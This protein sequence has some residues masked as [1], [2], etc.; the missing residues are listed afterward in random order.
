MQSSSHA[1]RE[2]AGIAD[3]EKIYLAARERSISHRWNDFFE[4][5]LRLATKL[6][7]IASI[8]KHDRLKRDWTWLEDL[9][10]DLSPRY[11]THESD[12]DRRVH[13][14]DRLRAPLYDDTVE[15]RG[16]SVTADT[17]VTAT[18]T[19]IYVSRGVRSRYHWGLSCAILRAAILPSNVGN[20]VYRYPFSRSYPFLLHACTSSNRAT[21]GWGVQAQYM[22]SSYLFANWHS[23]TFLFQFVSKVDIQFFISSS[24]LTLELTDYATD[25]IVN[26]M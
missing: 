20:T 16:T 22:Y 1:W 21:A 18:V 15:P 9:K 26:S 8:V 10:Y 2:R 13:T 4:R 6:G 12:S 23:T 17:L 19:R 14:G 7:R 3:R 5:R 25:E 24:F 11:L